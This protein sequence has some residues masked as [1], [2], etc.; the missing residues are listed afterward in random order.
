MPDNDLTVGDDQE[1]PEEQVAEDATAAD[2]DVVE[3]VDDEEV[4]VD[5]AVD[6]VEEML[7]EKRAART[8]TRKQA[9]DL[10]TATLD[11]LRKLK[12]VRLE[13]A[14]PYPLQSIGMKVMLAPCNVTA[15]MSI[16]GGIFEEGEASQVEM[17]FAANMK[18]VI[19]CM[20]EPSVENEEELADLLREGAA[21]VM[22]LFTFC[23]EISGVEDD[24]PMGVS[25]A[26]EMAV[27]FTGATRSS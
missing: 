1:A 9:M 21:D 14:V 18:L 17:A 8:M 27:D 12:D 2:E 10:P 16:I 4:D 13:R 15:L 11:D 26:V 22:G 6:R 7:A 3:V 20:V 25:R 24:V 5:A 23:R 19:A